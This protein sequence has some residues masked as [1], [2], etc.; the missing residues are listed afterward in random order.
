MLSRLF[1]VFLTF[2]IKN[3]GVFVFATTSQNTVLK[4]S[5]IV[6]LPLMHISLKHFVNSGSYE[7]IL[8]I[9]FY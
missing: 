8:S 1:P 3:A 7:G 9:W 5:S 2:Q 4:L 6:G